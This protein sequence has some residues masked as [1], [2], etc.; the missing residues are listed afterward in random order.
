MLTLHRRSWLASA[1]GTFATSTFIAASAL[2]ASAPA[3]AQTAQTSAADEDPHAA[4]TTVTWVPPEIL[5]RPVPLREGVGNAQDA[6]T[7]K[8]DEARAFYIQGLNY[9]H[10]YVW[11]EAMRSFHQALRHDPDFAMAYWG[12][13]RMQS[14]LDDHDSAVRSARRAEEL[15]KQATPREQRRIALRLLQLDAIASIADQ[16]K[17]QAYKQAIDKALVA[18]T[19]DIELWLIRGNA[20]EPT[21][22]GRGQRGG[23]GSTAFYQEALRRSPDNAAAHHYLIHSYETINR[24]DA[25]LV[26]GEKYAGLSPAIPHAHHMWAHDLRRVGRI[27]DA[28]AAFKRTDDLE[29]AYYA[30]EGISP[31]MDWHHVHNLDLLATSYQH[32]GKMKQA[33]AL[34]RKAESLPSVT[35]YLEFNQKALT[36]FLFGRERWKDA[37]IAADKLTRGK[38]PPTRV[39]GYALAG[40]VH[41]E[42]GKRDAAAVALASA[43]R[44]LAEVPEVTAGIAVN[45]NAVRPYVDMLRG[46]MLLRDGETEKGREL[47]E[48]VQLQLRALPGPDA[49]TQALFRLEAIARIAREVGDWELAGFTA[50]QMMEHD[51]AFGGSQL[52][53]AL[54]AQHRGDASEMKSALTSARQYWKDADAN[55]RELAVLRKMESSGRVASARVAR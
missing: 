10:G 29:N 5:S 52:A 9:L 31:E 25:A 28:I 43:E 51:P 42:R 22:A 17:F 39:V 45:R 24:I 2:L 26:H 32:K 27:D 40:H 41:L 15:A 16:A 46:D 3:S 1:L 19:D 49:W 12:M 55:I 36:M 54:V 50:K 23:V 33:E 38:Y 48:T 47:L 4:C 6:V 13:S 20:E 53:R 34:L 7:T 14:G 30:A 37:L 21:A 11:I 44:E 18:D 35:N 8:S